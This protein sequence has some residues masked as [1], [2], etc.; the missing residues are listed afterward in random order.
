MLL[1]Q[2]NKWFDMI[3]SKNPKHLTK[4]QVWKEFGFCPPHTTLDQRKQ[5]LKKEIS[6]YSFYTENEY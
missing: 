4:Y 2:V 5:I 6:P 1:I 3:S